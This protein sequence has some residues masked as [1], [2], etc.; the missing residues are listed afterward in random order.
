MRE[1]QVYVGVDVFGRGCLGGGGF[2]S[3]IAVKFC[4]FFLLHFFP[5]SKIILMFKNKTG[6]SSLQLRLLSGSV[7][8]WMDVGVRKQPWQRLP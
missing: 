6:G 2:D 1:S 8:P 3:K 4:S 5:L 7:C